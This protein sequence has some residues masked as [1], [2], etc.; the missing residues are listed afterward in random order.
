MKYYYTQLNKT[1][2]MEIIAPNGSSADAIFR[3][4][5]PSTLDS[6]YKRYTTAEFESTDMFE[7]GNYGEK[8]RARVNVMLVTTAGISDTIDTEIISPELKEIINITINAVKCG[9][10]FDT[11]NYDDYQ[12]T[13]SKIANAINDDRRR[14]II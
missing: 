2:W 5:N 13:I 7:N 6:E 10:K 14:D 4:Y 11:E 8:C 12:N 1:G 9:V 3:A